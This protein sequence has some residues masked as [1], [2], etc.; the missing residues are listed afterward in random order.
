MKKLF[1]L[2]ALS[3]TLVLAQGNT[4][5]MNGQ[6]TDPA[7]AAVPGAQVAVT[8]V[9][10]KAV[11]RT[12]TN[13]RGEYALPSMPSGRYEVSVSH[14]GF[15]A[16]KKTG[17]EMAAGVDATV[18][19]KLEIGQATETVTVEAGAEIVQTTNAELSTTITGR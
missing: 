16:I 1:L 9:D 10:T 6:V 12:T 18:N 17:V 11:V 7:G 14:P 19:V 4:G 8:N 2:L 15:K 13:E 5:L 3:T